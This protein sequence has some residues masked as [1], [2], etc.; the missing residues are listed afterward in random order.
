MSRLG[1]Y[2]TLSF[3]HP[4]VDID[5]LYTKISLLLHKENSQILQTPV[6]KTFHL[7]WKIGKLLVEA[8]HKGIIRDKERQ[9]I[10]FKLSERL[11]KNFGKEFDLLAL[12]DSYKFYL[13]YPPASKDNILSEIADISEFQTSLTWNH[14]RLLIHVDCLHARNFYEKEARNSH[15]SF[16]LLE[17]FIKSCLFERLSTSPNKESVLRSAQQES[18][19]LFSE[20]RSSLNKL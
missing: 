2:V 8:E 19:N 18:L 1:E 10:L 12:E 14:Y 11:V 16:S 15:W 7:Y 13:V 20:N 3:T 6:V 4:S 9:D 17:K 5:K